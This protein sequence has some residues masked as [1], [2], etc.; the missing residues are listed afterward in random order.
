MPRLADAE[1]PDVNAPWAFGF[2][3]EEY[4]RRRAATLTLAEEKGA[5][6]VL[7]FG[8]NR[9]G[10]AVT[11]L[12][13][14]PVSRLAVHRLAEGE[15]RLWVQ[16]HN[17]VPQARRIA[18][19]TEVADAAEGYVDRLLDGLT[20]AATLGS[21]PRPVAG[22]AR[23]RG[24]ELVPLDAAHARL[25]RIKSV[26]EREALS[27]GARASDAGA[28][29]LI[30]ACVPGATDWDLLAAARSA[31]S[32][33]GARDHICYI[34]V[35]DMADPDRDVP[36]QV[37]EGRVLRRG[38]VVTFELSAAVA[39]EYPGQVLRTVTLGEPTDTYVRLHEVAMQ[40]RSRMRE[41]MRPGVPARELI[42]AAAVI[43]EAGLTTTDDLFHGLGMGY[44]EPIGSSASR[45]PQQVPAID[46]AAGMAVVVQPNVTTTDH[47][48]GVQTGEM[49][50]VTPDGIED[51]H[52]LEPGL[53][54]RGGSS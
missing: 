38:S 50:L 52:R 31:Y 6:A 20:R 9:S 11:Y 29:A 8:E 53:V 40:A 25:R 47:R 37:P 22:A 27:L 39:A 30:D 32:R 15:S 42:T 54:I 49:V 7:S 35:T 13:G 41:A 12:T 28:A 45:E 23:E 36:S 4:T 24:V 14:W 2:P 19:D 18:V 3:A 34:G 46:L 44:L 10:A 1:V 21:V 5:D 17:H 43:E 51:I 33:L 16:F 48:A 26:A